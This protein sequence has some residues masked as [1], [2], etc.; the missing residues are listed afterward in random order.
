[1][2]E[3]NGPTFRDFAGAVMEGNLERASGLLEL[4][5]ALDAEAAR[6]AAA[7]FQAQ[8]AAGG[9]F[10]MKAMGMRTVVESGSED[11]LTQLIVDLFGLDETQA[12]AS[13]GAVIVRFRS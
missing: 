2:S 5:L 3:T 6:A 10:M 13:A 11:E 4:L 7:R 1:M 12:R 9:D 8:M